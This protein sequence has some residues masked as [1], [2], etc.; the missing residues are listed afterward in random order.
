MLMTMSRAVLID[1]S[2]SCYF[3]L[4]AEYSLAAITGRSM[5]LLDGHWSESND[6][7]HVQR[8]DKILG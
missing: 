1:A 2:L 5:R 7:S 4:Q 3:E 6:R 8:P